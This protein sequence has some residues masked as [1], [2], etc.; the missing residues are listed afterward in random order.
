MKPNV[1]GYDIH[2]VLNA[3]SRLLKCYDVRGHLRWSV[4]AR[5]EGVAG[6]GWTMPYGDTPPGLYRCGECRPT[7]PEDPASVH[8]SYGPWF[9]YLLDEEPRARGGHT[10]IGIHGG[11]DTTPGGRPSH[12]GAL[13]MTHGCIRVDNEDLRGRVVPA[14]QF[15][16]RHGGVAWL[17]VVWE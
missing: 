6:P 13:A 16:Q 15:T 7:L 11:R 12:P 17:T 10:G 5:G 1:V 9:I 14:V 8:E 4:M 3:R 2:L